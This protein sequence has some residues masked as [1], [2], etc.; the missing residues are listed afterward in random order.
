MICCTLEV[1]DTKVFLG[2]VGRVVLQ[3]DRSYTPGDGHS[4]MPSTGTL[5]A[6]SLGL[7]TPAGFLVPCASSAR[8]GPRYLILTRLEMKLCTTN[9]IHMHVY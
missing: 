7:G 2:K 8:E 1:G 9:Y 3:A 5:P 6:H 4:W